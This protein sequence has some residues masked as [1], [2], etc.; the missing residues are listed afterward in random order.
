VHLGDRGGGH[1]LRIE[2]HEDLVE[3]APV[4]LRQ[5]LFDLAEGE[6]ADIVANGPSAPQLD[7]A[8]TRVHKHLIPGHG[9]ID[10]E[11]TLAAIAATDYAGWITVELYPYIDSPDNAASAAHDYLATLGQRLGIRWQ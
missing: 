7:I 1:G 4:V 2:R 8:A 11:A 3:G 5:D 9:A 10:F 6:G